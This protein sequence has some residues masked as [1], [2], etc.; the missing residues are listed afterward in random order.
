MVTHMAVLSTGEIKRIDKLALDQH[1]G[2]STVDTLATDGPVEMGHTKAGARKRNTED[3][4][5]FLASFPNTVTQSKI[6]HCCFTKR[7]LRGCKQ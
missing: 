5:V 2:D 3:A 7:G 4:E 1:Y 6:A